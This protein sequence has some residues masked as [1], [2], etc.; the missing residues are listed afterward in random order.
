[1][2]YRRLQAWILAAVGVVELF[3]FPSA[4]MPREW[5]QAGHAWLGM[6]EMPEGPVFEAV[7]RQ[8][9]FSYGLHGAALLLIASDVDRYRPLVILSAIGY[10]AY[11]LVF[12]FT[13]IGLGMPRL[14]VAGNAGSTILIGVLLLGLIWAEH[15]RESRL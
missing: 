3:A 1:M 10:L 15:R 12:L 7:M 6:G 2:N 5:M 8:V 11:G 9:S 4:V 13:D 14:W